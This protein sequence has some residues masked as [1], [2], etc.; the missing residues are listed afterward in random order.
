MV[1]R[2]EVMRGEVRRRM[3]GVRIEEMLRILRW[4]RREKRTMKKTEAMR[5][6]REKVCGQLSWE[7]GMF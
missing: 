3:L 7:A 6:E 1:K 5:G 4:G 2:M